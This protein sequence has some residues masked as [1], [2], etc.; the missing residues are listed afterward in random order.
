[1]SDGDEH[2]RIVGIGVRPTGDF[3]TF[4]VGGSALGMRDTEQAQGRVRAT[5]VN[6]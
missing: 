2:G 1:M 3:V 6:A 5:S 4:G